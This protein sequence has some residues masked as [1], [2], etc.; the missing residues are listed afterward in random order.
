M[1]G[2]KLLT[3]F[4]IKSLFLMLV[5]GFS[6]P[7]TAQR[8]PLPL[9][10]REGNAQQK[11]SL[12]YR[13]SFSQPHTHLYEVMFSIGNIRTASVD[14]QMPVW[15]PG[16]Y[17]VREFARNVQDFDVRD[18]T[19]Q[20]LPWRKTDKATWRVEVGGM[21]TRPRDIKV[22]YRVYANELSVRTSHVDASHAYF[23]G[24]SVFLYVKGAVDQ[25]LKLKIE[26]P[27]AWKVTT[28]LGLAPDPDD[29]YQAP[30]Y[31]I[32][33]DSP[34]EV[35]NHRLLEF[36]VRGKR[37]RIAIWGE[38]NYEEN[39][40]KE[41]VAKI[42]EQGALIFGELPYDHY[43]FFVHLQP[44][45]GG[46]LE[47]LNSTTLHSRPDSFAPRR[48]YVRFLGLVSHEYFHLWNVKRI[49]PQVLGPFDYQHENYT[50][51]LWVSEGITDYYGSQLLRR[52]QLITP[53]EY[54]EEFGRDI[55]NYEQTPGRHEQ[56]AE[57]ASFDA[58]IKHYRP[59]EN[60][61]NTAMS[62]Y[63]RGSLLG[64][65][66]DLEIRTKTAGAR[67]LDDAMRYLYDNYARRGVGFPEGELKGVFE[68]IAGTDLSDFFKNYVSG[69]AEI[70]FDRYLQLSGLELRRG[71][72]SG[73]SDNRD[74]PAGKP[75]WLGC[76]LRV[77]E[78]RILINNVIAGTSGYDV[79]LNAADE[80]VALDGWRLNSTNYTERF[81][82]LRE[83][84]DVSLTVFRRERLMTF[85][86]KADKRPFD[87]YS[88]APIKDASPAQTK[89]RQSWLAE[90]VNG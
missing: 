79:G 23:N 75:G 58:W 52:A 69:T 36:D 86:L 85:T 19:G 15:T 12:E 67:T 40:L 73:V 53:A 35:G 37:H 87:R 59:D 88:I 34:A 72:A 63:L 11:Y 56:S 84:Q 14:L 44:A 68:K 54:L 20:P 71:Y 4:L 24:G 42:V 27:A 76:R 64:W 3:L 5:L 43:T 39:R 9:A 8:R 18:G 49:R 89:L 65:L 25:P 46:G 29:F 41:D 61:P 2:R 48:A 38:G 17:L 55:M 30:N 80:L 47:H 90:G 7:L 45:I 21:G 70:D 83:G 6:V 32:L 16:S 60:E 57:S 51:A 74:R 62:Y 10:T 77:S 28:S 1:I 31:D 33:V 82:H 26:A 81:D 22:T 50:R 13:L 66:L 78:G